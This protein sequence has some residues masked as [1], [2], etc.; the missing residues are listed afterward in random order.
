MGVEI[1]SDGMIPEALEEEL[2]RQ[3]AAGELARVK[4]KQL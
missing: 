2:G 4:A 1:D 3:K